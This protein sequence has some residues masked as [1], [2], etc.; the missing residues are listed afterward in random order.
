MKTTRVGHTGPTHAKLQG[1]R[2]ELT[3]ALAADWDR[4]QPSSQCQ[5][6]ITV[7]IVGLIGLLVMYCIVRFIGGR[8]PLSFLYS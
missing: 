3:A 2:V 1:M 4:V 7:L 8:N 6:R 5:D